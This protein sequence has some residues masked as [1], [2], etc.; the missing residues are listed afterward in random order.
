M[1]DL[2]LSDPRCSNLSCHAFAAGYNASEAELPWLS[3]LEY[4]RWT[5]YYY[6]FWVL[7]FTVF[8][9]YHIFQ[10]QIQKRRRTNSIQCPTW[11]QKTLAVCRSLTYRRFTQR[12]SDTMGLPSWGLLAILALSTVFLAVLPFIEQPYVRKLFRYGS[13]PISIRCAMII[14]ALTP[15]TVTLPGKVNV[16]TLLTGVCYT[17]LNI[18]HRFV[19][20]MLFALATVHTIPHLVSPIQDGGI[21][22]L[23]RLYR[24]KKR[25]LSGTALYAVCFG[26]AFFSIPWIRKRAYEAFAYVHIFLA[27]SYVALLWWHIDGE[28]M[29]P[30]YLYVTIGLWATSFLIRGFFRNRL[31]PVGPAHSLRGY[32]TTLKHLPGNITRIVVSVP[33][34]LTWRPGQ[35]AYIRMPKLSILD[36]HPF[37]IASIP[38]QTKDCEKEHKMV[39]LVRAHTGFT[40]TLSTHAHDLRTLIDGPYGAHLRPLHRIYDDIICVAGGTG[41]TAILPMAM[42]LAEKMSRVECVLKTV[43]LVWMIRD[44]D[45]LSWIQEEIEQ[46]KSIAAGSKGRVILDVYVTARGPKPVTAEEILES[47]AET[48]V[49]M[50]PGFL[51]TT[52]YLKPEISQLLPDLIKGPRSLVLGCGPD[53]MKTSLSNTIAGLQQRVL[54]GNMME[55]AL[56]TETF[57]W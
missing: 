23:S 49:Q 55:V 46:V 57:G 36:N 26:L 18:I 54:S 38:R 47:S 30:N 29:S 8:N 41:I 11:R 34:N 48:L 32:P 5:I 33:G 28:Y 19:A 14:S 12:W 56:R 4:G 6:S 10:D 53:A 20:Y 51:M 7:L 40:H 16:I 42:H 22:N 2:P 17:K 13:P 1:V 44:K 52:H 21:D 25:E 50:S 35:H 9:L 39:F 45:W 43:R 15:L 27:I 37:T 3:Q 24:E 31:F